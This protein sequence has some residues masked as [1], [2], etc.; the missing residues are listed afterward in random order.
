[1]QN[2]PILT[3][4]FRQIIGM[5]NLPLKGALQDDQLEIIEEGGILMSEGSIQS[6]GRFSDMQSDLPPQNIKLLEGDC[7]ALP[8]MIDAHTHICFAGSRARDYSMR[9]GGKTYL[10]IA[11]EGGGIWDTVSQTRKASLEELKEGVLMRARL[12][13]KNG[14]TTVE[15]KSGYGL[16]VEEELKMLR[17][18]KQADEILDMLVPT[19]LAAH[20]PPRDYEGSSNSY[21]YEIH[22]TLWPLIQKEGLANRMDIF[23]EEGAFG[24]EEARNY[25]L[26][27]KD[28]RFDLVMHVDQFHPGGSHLAVELDALSA[29]HLEASGDREI[30]LLAGS[31]VIPIA[32]PGA[33]LGL[34]DRFTPAR[35]L[36]DA[37]TSLVIASDWNP[38]SAPM[39]DLL[40]QAAILGASQKL[41]MAETWAAMTFRAAAALRLED[42]GVIEAGK[43]ADVVAF[44][45]DD[46]REILYRQGQLRP[47]HVWKKGVPFLSP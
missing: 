29:D 18:I 31:D 41:S 1:M 16:S 20:I 12:L 37:G 33:S 45:T 40:T 7:V 35:K 13:L 34:G 23:I 10:E 24:M 27:A 32:L 38:G 6:V 21:L 3:G 26:A 44:P 19:C 46:Y 8:G 5:K 15:V 30:E 25:M 42:R 4:P 36:L 47:S 11:K 43:R 9:V 17:A 39:G 22:S 14:V 2:T 28:F